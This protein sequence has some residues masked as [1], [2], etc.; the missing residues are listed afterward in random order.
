[1]KLGNNFMGIV[2][3]CKC[4]YTTNQYTI[5]CNNESIKFDNTDVEIENCHLKEDITKLQE[6]NNELAE[7][8][9]VY[10]LIGVFDNFII[11]RIDI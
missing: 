4:N 9:K 1:M 6:E 11:R 7:L 3:T 2:L 5:A 10:K 8:Q